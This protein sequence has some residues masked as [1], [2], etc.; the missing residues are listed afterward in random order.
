MGLLDN[1]FKPKP[2]TGGERLPRAPRKRESKDR[3]MTTSDDHGTPGVVPKPPQF[4]AP[5]N[6]VPRSSMQVVPPT[7]GHPLP[8]RKAASPE[9][10]ARPQMAKE[11]VL[12]LGDVLSR[13]PAHFLRQGMPDAHRELRFPCR[14]TR[15]RH[16]ARSRLGFARGHR[17]A[18]PGNLC[19][20]R[21]RLSPMSRFAFRCKARRTDR[22]D[23]AC[24][25]LNSTGTGHCRRTKFAAVAKELAGVELIGGGKCSVFS[26]Q[27]ARV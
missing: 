20:G 12:T 9:P 21:G 16:R 17:R 25:A 24:G 7:R 1:L 19:R 27:I 11:I 6:Y 10:D 2:D 3:L 22:D 15:R 23:N 8:E 5:K 4:L 26:V 14:R 13:I 18:V